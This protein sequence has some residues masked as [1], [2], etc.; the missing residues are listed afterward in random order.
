MTSLSF[1]S[2]K[3]NTSS[4]PINVILLYYTNSYIFMCHT[5]ITFHI[6]VSLH[7]YKCSY[8]CMCHN[9][10]LRQ[11]KQNL[12]TFHSMNKIIEYQHRLLSLCHFDVV[13]QTEKLLLPHQHFEN[14][15]KAIIVKYLDGC[16]HSSLN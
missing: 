14:Y 6:I 10:R 1:I 16:F 3:S 9:Y 13:Y 8:T 2:S 11:R 5:C 15:Q 12:I 7:K 4:T